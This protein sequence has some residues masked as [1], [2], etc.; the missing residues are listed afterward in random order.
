MST[1]A[2]EAVMMQSPVGRGASRGFTL[3][4]LVMVI[5][6]AGILATV[7]GPR[8]FTPS[9]FTQRAYADDVA[10]ALRLA[11]KAAVASDCPARVSL[12]AGS[13]VVQQQAASGNTCNTS[14]TTWSTPVVGTDG[15]AA[16]GTAPAGTTA[17]PT[18]AYVFNGS[19]ALSSSPG[20]TL[21][22]GVNTIT[23]DAL[24]GYIQEQ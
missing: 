4:E 24:T 20:S 13:Y 19:G 16:A 22:V 8:F 6:I 7:A 1:A 3:I 14:D 5:V 15:V 18:G 12:S 17:S 10:G 11:Q 21:T 2:Q 23:I 9:V